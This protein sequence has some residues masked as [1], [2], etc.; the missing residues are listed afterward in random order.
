MLMKNKEFSDR[1]SLML[2]KTWHS[3]WQT[4]IDAHEKHGIQSDTPSLMLMKNM[5]FRV[6]DKV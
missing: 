3:E 1:P 2:M 4:K 6:A 5:A